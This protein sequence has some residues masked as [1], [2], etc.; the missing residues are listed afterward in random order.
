MTLLPDKRRWS[1]FG[2]WTKSMGPGG[3]EVW[4]QVPPRPPI[5]EFLGVDAMGPRTPI[6]PQPNYSPAPWAKPA[7]NQSPIPP[8]SSIARSQPQQESAQPQHSRQGD[9]Q[10]GQVPNDI[11]LAAQA[12]QRK[13]NVP[14]SIT[15]AQWMLESGH[16]KKMP[17]GSKNPFGIKA[18]KGQPFVSAPT[19]EQAKDGR[20]ISIIAPFRKF[21]SV[22]E[23]FDLHGKLLATNHHYASARE[24]AGDPNSY[25]RALT[26]TYASDSKYGGLL[27]SLMRQHNLYQYDVSSR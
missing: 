2:G 5:R 10:D 13:W 25:A 27:I 12:A 23:A 17:A 3:Q 15:I 1:L 14:A 22:D 6:A 9:G 7:P 19:K 21:D 8:A 26:G 4:K 20:M 24:H 16:G 18:V 11:V